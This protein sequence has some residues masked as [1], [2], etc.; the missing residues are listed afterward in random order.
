MEQMKVGFLLEAK[1]IN[2]VCPEL[3]FRYH[4]VATLADSIQWQIQSI[5]PHGPN[6]I[7]YLLLMGTRCLGLVG[8]Y[9]PPTNLNTL[10]HDTAT[11]DCLH[12]DCTLCSLGT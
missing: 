6:V 3:S 1:L 2:S 7:S 10:A 4:I 8:A 12:Q 9:I 11:L 5:R